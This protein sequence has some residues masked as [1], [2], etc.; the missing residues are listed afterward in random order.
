[1]ADATQP[2]SE[3][4]NQP[5]LGP[6][7]W[8]R[9]AWRRLTS[10]S[11]ALLL[12]LL[13]AVAAVPGSIVPQRRVDP[14]RV[15]TYLDDH[16][17]LGPWLDRFGFFDVYS[18]PWFAAVYV[19]LFVSLVGC[20]VPR[21]RQHWKAMRARPPRTPRR[22]DRMPVYLSRTAPEGMD[23]AAVLAAAR[24]A[25]R[26]RRYRIADD[27]GAVAAEKGYLAETGNLLFHLA[28]LGVL[29]AIAVGAMFS[30][31]G[32][33][34]LVEGKTFSNTLPMYDAFRPGTRVDPEALPPFS[35][36][37][38]ELDVAFDE[39][40]T[41]SQFAAPRLFDARV[42]VRP[43]PGAPAEERLVRPNQPLDVN[44]VRAFLVGNGYAPVLTVRD[45]NGDVAF[46]GPVP[47]RPRDGMYTSLGVVKVPDAAPRQVAFTG[48]LLPTAIL[49]PQAGPISIFPDARTPRLLLTTFAGDEGQDD[50]GLD[51]GVPQSIYSLDTRDLT[52][53][54]APAGEGALGTTGQL[55]L[56][57]GQTV[58]LPD[59]L[60]S[61]TFEEL[62][63][64][65]AFDVHNDPSKGWA[66][67]SGMISLAGL[68][69][70]LFILRRR[71]WVRV[72][73]DEQGRTVVEVAGLPRGEDAGLAAEVEALAD[74]SSSGRL[75]E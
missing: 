51:S 4:I 11:T 25:L 29:V 16:P 27:D 69:L 72:S 57:P 74:D 73:R 33:V 19:L 17:T 34:V 62:R 35:F 71:V 55:L 60:G 5:T 10:M 15:G 6:V 37:L 58:T 61:I 67:G 46:S 50:I 41:G 8:A 1:M 38:E 23:E 42:S 31:T 63:R 66:L 59:G 7:G 13:L 2:A 65:A 3:Q 54:D 48:F 21:A 24:Q 22:L 56:A 9:F 43:A 45:G 68:M 14:G 12:L 39:E 47:F 32:Q 53:V 28:L 44:G 52:R 40:S 49:D 75:R 20:V 70:S 26:R 30:W 18:S 36:T 64:F